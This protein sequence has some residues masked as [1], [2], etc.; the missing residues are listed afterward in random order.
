[1]PTALLVE[2]DPDVMSITRD[3][4]EE[5][6]FLVVEAADGDQGLARLAGPGHLD[7]L[8]TDCDM[9]GRVNGLGLLAEAARLRP[10]LARVMVTGSMIDGS[11]GDVAVLPKPYRA[12]QVVASVHRAMGSSLRAAG[13]ASAF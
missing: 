1:M 12:H 4:L 10:G 8:V 2:D 6:G 11:V 5:A 13:A 7:V 3:M 9:P